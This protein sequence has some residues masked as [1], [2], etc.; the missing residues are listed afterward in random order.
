MT[1]YE[2]GYERGRDEILAMRTAV[3]AAHLSMWSLGS[4]HAGSAK[5]TVRITGER[6]VIWMSDDYFD[7]R[8]GG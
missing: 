4:C 3:A 7:K 6:N 8:D 5:E 2:K 1:D